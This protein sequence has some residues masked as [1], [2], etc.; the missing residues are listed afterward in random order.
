M[1][2][3]IQLILV[4]GRVRFMASVPFIM[5]DSKRAFSSKKGALC[6]VAPTL[7]QVMGLSIPSEMDGTSLLK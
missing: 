1:E 4:I 3:L 5:T 7:L 2:N 6:D